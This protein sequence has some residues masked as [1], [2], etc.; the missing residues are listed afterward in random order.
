MNQFIDPVFDGIERLIV[1]RLLGIWVPPKSKILRG[2]EEL[3]R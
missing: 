3:T 2:R 1:D